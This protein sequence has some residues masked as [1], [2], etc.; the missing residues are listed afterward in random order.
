MILG[1]KASQLQRLDG[2]LCAL[3]ANKGLVDVRNDSTAS[4]GSLDEGV[5][6][7]VSSNGE[8]QV[9]R[10]DT[11]HLQILGGVASQ[12]QHLCCEVL[13]DGSAVDCGSGSHAP[14]G[15]GAVLEVPVDTPHREL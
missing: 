3:L 11:L 4:N 2:L 14:M 1:V 7:F 15:G 10:R 5:E 8:L 13:E 6:L 12:L 9:T